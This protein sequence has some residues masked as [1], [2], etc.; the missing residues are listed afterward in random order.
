MSG[1]SMNGQLFTAPDDLNEAL[2]TPASPVLPAPFQ[3]NTRGGSHSHSV[4]DSVSIQSHISIAPSATSDSVEPDKYVPALPPIQAW[5]APKFKALGQRI[6]KAPHLVLLLTI[7]ATAACTVGLIYLR[8]ATPA[9][10]ACKIRT[11]QPTASGHC[12]L[13]TIQDASYV[14]ATGH[15][16]CDRVNR[17]G[18]RRFKHCRTCLV[19]ISHMC[20]GWTRSRCGYGCRRTRAPPATNATTTHSSGLSIG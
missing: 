1:V 3:R 8:Y 7:V 15:G 6:A 2:L 18:Q 13:R 5:L 19:V 9:V 10:I 16:S 20:A 14:H 12:R 11:E 17:C 4:H